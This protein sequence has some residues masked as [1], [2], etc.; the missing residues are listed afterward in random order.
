MK[1][2]TKKVRTRYKIAYNLDT[3]TNELQTKF[4]PVLQRSTYR[5]SQ[6]LLNMLLSGTEASF[7]QLLMPL[8]VLRPVTDE[9]REYSVYVMK[10]EEKDTKLFKERKQI[11]D[12]LRLTFDN[13]MESLF[14]DVQYVEHCREI[15][16]ERVFDMTEAEAEEY[17]QGIQELADKIRSMTDE[18]VDAEVS[19]EVV[20]EK[21]INKEV[22]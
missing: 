22:S 6:M 3:E 10:D 13:I 9:E 17:R 1:E 19:S 4:T 2:D 21:I 20:E 8:P 16:Q 11:H 14:P 15:Q 18:E 5:D 12:A 7:N